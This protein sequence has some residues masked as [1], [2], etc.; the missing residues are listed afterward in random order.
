MKAS[1]SNLFILFFILIVL[2][3]LYRKFEDK[4]ILQESDDTYQSIQ[5]YL[6][7]DTVLADSKKPILWIHVPY[8]F[9]SR[10]WLNFGSRNSFQLNQPYLYLTV[11]SILAQCDQS[12]TVCFFDDNTF[13]RLLPQWD[14]DM[15]ALSDPILGNM[16]L[17]GC[18]RLLQ[19][20]GGMLCPISFL[21]MKDLH[22]LY[23]KGTRSDKMF[24][25]ET[26][27]RNITSSH[28]DFSP[29]FAF[30]GAPKDCDM[31]REFCDFIRRTM[32]TDFTAESKFLGSFD[33][34]CLKRV[35]TR[36]M[37]LV[38]GV[39]IGTKTVDDKPILLDDLMSNQY[40]N[41]YKDAFGIFIPANEL[42]ARNHYAWFA[43]LSAKQAMQSNTIVGSY[44]LLANAPKD[45]IDGRD[46]RIGILRPFETEQNKSIEKSFVSFW[47]VPSDAP[48]WGLKP[49][50]LGNNLL[51]HRHPSN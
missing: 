18:M 4:R 45:H 8:E 42:L 22:S 50:Q 21:C 23:L 5:D 34:W 3:I 37:N 36:A 38:D 35:H 33:R 19:V 2:G 15:T 46:T 49:I 27:T 20:Y 51:R 17:L 6:L 31:V 1:S 39:D 24:V 11:K 7:D 16:R 14:V 25:C 32:S 9:N 44:L 29:T 48:V 28:Y 40:L 10:N 41:L 47:R 30:C 26:T 12:F 13:Q 43:R